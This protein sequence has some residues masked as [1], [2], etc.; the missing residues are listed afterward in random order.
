MPAAARSGK[1]PPSFGILPITGN[2]GNA[3]IAA[4]EP[5]HSGERCP[6]GRGDQKHSR[7]TRTWSQQ[8]YASRHWQGSSLRAASVWPSHRA[9]VAE[10]LAVA[11]ELGAPGG[12]AGP[13][14]PAECRPARPAAAR[15]RLPPPSE[16][17]TAAAPSIT[18]ARSTTGRAVRG[19]LA[20]EEPG[21]PEAHRPWAPA[22]LRRPAPDSPRRTSTA[23]RPTIIPPPGRL[24]LRQIWARAL[25]P[26]AEPAPAVDFGSQ[27]LS[28]AAALGTFLNSNPADSKAGRVFSSR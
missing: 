22:S 24:R 20:S 25:A 9:V 14:V 17:P 13:E 26:A 23:V 11:E 10:E 21:R 3:A 4:A 7:R 8:D 28:R 19:R 16:R 12:Q 15:Q 5:R 6:P 2:L 1:A 27:G 18:T